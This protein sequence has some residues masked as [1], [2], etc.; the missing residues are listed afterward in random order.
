[1][2]YSKNVNLS[3]DTRHFHFKCQKIFHGTWQISFTIYTAAKTKNSQDAPGEPILLD[4]EKSP[5]L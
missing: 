3:I 1:M 5:V 2:Q 4:K